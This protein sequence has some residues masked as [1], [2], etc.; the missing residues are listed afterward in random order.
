LKVVHYREKD[1]SK[2]TC[3]LSV[4]VPIY[5]EEKRI[6]KCVNS[7]LNQTYDN[8]ELILVDDGSTDNSAVICEEYVSKNKNVFVI[9]TENLGI[10]QARKTGVENAKGEIL[11]FVDADDWIDCNAFETAV[12]VFSEYN[13]DM[14]I[15]TY[16]D[17][18]NVIEENLYE[19]KLYCRQEIEDRIIPTMMYD[20]TIGR[21]RLNPSLCCKYIKKLIYNEI[22]DSVNDMITLGEDALVTYSAVC[23]SRSIYIC[24]KALYHYS[25]NSLSCMHTFSIDWFAQ[26][27]TFQQNCIRIFSKLNLIDKLS[28]QIESYVRILLLMV[29]KN[30]YGIEL[31]PT[32]YRFPYD[33]V[34]RNARIFI[35][36]AGNVGKSYV[37][38]LKINNYASIVGWG[39]KNYAGIRSYNN[40]RVI[41]PCQIKEVVFDV[42]LI[43]VL[44]DKIAK[45][46]K[47]NLINMGVSESKIIWRK[48]IQIV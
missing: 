26:I 18:N 5:N 43:A 35:Y 16:Q 7:I 2:N 31:S 27:K 11:T 25:N 34:P 45:N 44:D 10:F 8:F 21:R 46:I 19:E 15:Y 24:S 23:V 42:L 38:E 20:I 37:N 30:W 28:F 3:N 22:T 4:I 12:Q 33:C 48:P 47:N 39:D 40:V 9:H 1:M 17:E 14:Y 32:S 6:K 13:P 29:V 41:A 36:G